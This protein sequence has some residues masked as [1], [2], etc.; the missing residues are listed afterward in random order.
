MRACVRAC[1]RVYVFKLQV[2][3]QLILICIGVLETS[4][5]PRKQSIKSDNNKKTIPYT[6]MYAC[7]YVFQL[8]CVFAHS[9]S[10]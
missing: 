5:R 10:H 6:H 9:M 8:E 1:A 2:I 3:L 7:I 4:G